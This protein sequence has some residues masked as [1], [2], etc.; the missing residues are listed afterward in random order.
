M[1]V[2][3]EEE[4]M[5]MKLN[6]EHIDWPGHCDDWDDATHAD[7]YETNCLLCIE[8]FQD[9]EEFLELMCTHIYHTTCLETAS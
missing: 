1:G 9:G 8:A 4:R 7:Q 6:N 2:E 5:R 3:R